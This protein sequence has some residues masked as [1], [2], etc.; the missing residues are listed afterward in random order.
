MSLIA[1]KGL[2]PNISLKK[3]KFCVKTKNFKSQAENSWK[4]E[5]SSPEQVRACSQPELKRIL[6]M[7]TNC[8]LCDQQDD[9]FMVQCD[10]C[11]LWFHFT[12]V[13]VTQ[14]IEQV[15]WMCADCTKAKS[16]DIF[17]SPLNKNQHAGNKTPD[18]G[19]GQT[20]KSVTGAIG[21][22]RVSVE[23]QR[24]T[25]S[26]SSKSSNRSKRDFEIKLKK[27]QDEHNLELLYLKRKYEILEAQNQYDS[28]Y[29]ES[30]CGENLNDGGRS[31]QDR[32]RLDGV[33]SYL[34]GLSNNQTEL[35]QRTTNTRRLSN[36][37]QHR[38]NEPI[39]NVL[40]QANAPTTFN[41]YLNKNQVYSR[42]VIPRELPIFS[43]KNEEWPLFISSFENSTK[44]CGFTDDEN[45]L[46]LQRALRGKAL[47][48][49][50]CKLT[51]PSLVP[52]VISTLRMLYGR[53]ESIIHNLLVKLRGGPNVNVNKLETLIS[54]SLDVKNIVATMQ[55]AH[56]YSHLNNP[57][58]IQEFIERL[59]SSMRLEWAVF[60]KNVREV[61]LTEFSNWLFNLAE[62]ASSVIPFSNLSLNES[63]EK[64]KATRVNMHT[65][66]I[67]EVN[68][69]EKRHSDAK[70]FCCDK[71]GHF[72]VKCEKFKS[73]EYNDKWNLIRDKKLCRSCLKP[74][75]PK[76]CRERK[77][78]RINGCTAKHS[79]LLHKRDEPAVEVNSS[80]SV[81]AVHSMLT[82]NVL[83]RI[84]PIDIHGKQNKITEYAL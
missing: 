72:I 23:L 3:L 38:T 75:D 36:N 52:E 29:E 77:E 34:A 39:H 7:D 26:V 84:I 22:S 78:C 18:D 71:I 11:D 59:P 67:P 82:T 2:I 41:T 13:G 33:E 64:R 31:N 60:S 53:P 79:F 15:E 16:A 14:E 30:E 80:N 65:E 47:E 12:C 48:F 4:S 56:L 63:N 24:K 73:L 69:N 55:A 35:D 51:L 70:C 25:F 46:R 27:L 19:G 9:D 44:L 57:M 28:E 45:L 83:Y 5:A 8:K 81:V 40:P 37:A 74:H 58:L 54:F 66:P 17:Q 68:N 43:G 10:V 6:K 20:D 76:F 1:Y 61:N 21:G 42:Q 32:A 50:S 62:A 49:V